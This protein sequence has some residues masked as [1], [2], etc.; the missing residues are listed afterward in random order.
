MVGHRSVA[1]VGTWALAMAGT[2]VALPAPAFGQDGSAAAP[3]NQADSVE[4]M[5][6]EL[7]QARAQIAEQKRRLDL[8]EQR[9]AGLAQTTQQ[10]RDEVAS[11][12]PAAPPQVALASPSLSVGEPPRDSDRAPTVAVLDQQGSV[13]TRKGELIGEVGFDYTRSDRNRAIFRGITFP[14]AVLIGV[15]DINEN[16]QDILS[17]SAGIRYGLTKRLELGV[18]VPFLYRADTLITAPISGS[19]NNDAA[20]EINSSTK[21]S[22]I[23][24][25]EVSARY[26]LNDGGRNRPFLIAN[27]QASIPTG[28]DPFSLNRVNGVATQ[29]ATGAGFWGITPG[30]TAILPSEPAVLFGTVGYTFNLARNVDTFLPPVQI[31]RLNPGDQISFAAGI[32]FSF[33]ER[34]SVNL[35][36]SHGWV[37]GSQTIFRAVNQ[38]GAIVGAPTQSESR[39]F[40]IGRLL[41]GVSHRFSRRLQVNWSI[42]A[43]L[44]EDAPDVRLALRVPV[45]F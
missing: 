38:A 22:G 14:Q 5:R 7:A 12:P 40:Q 6:A 4:A 18:R 32:G 2:A 42:D 27:L 24:D 3:G 25:I 26:Q 37:L 23:G 21:G 33:N 15:F 30:I 9:L 8:L 39:D 36:Y 13:I 43:G 10:I 34:T 19:T 31:D 17:A 11:A 20:R 28:R 45:Q 29:S 1:A 41:V 16:R 44:T 35:C